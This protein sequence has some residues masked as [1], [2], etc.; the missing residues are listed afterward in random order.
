MARTH[1]RAREL[2][3]RSSLG[4]G[5]GR[6]VQQLLLEHAWLGLLG[7]AIGLAL[8]WAAIRGVLALWGAQIPRAGEIAMDWRVFAFA[9][10]LSIAAGVLAGVVPA[11][12]ATRLSPR[13]LLESGGRG[14]AKGGRNLAGASLVSLEIAL[15]L[16]LLTGAGLL[17]QSFRSL[18]A[19]DIGFDT[20]VATAEAT[21]TGPGYAQDSLRRYAYWNQ[22]LDEFRAIPGV[23]FAAVSQWIPLGLTG[24]GFVDV[25]GRDVGGL[26]AVYRTVSTDFFRT[27]GVPVIVG[28]TFGAEDGNMTQ[29]VVVI[30][31]MMAQRFFPGVNP[32]GRRVRARSQEPG[33]NGRPAPWLTIIGVVGDIRTYGLESDARPEMYVDFRQTPW[34]TATMTGLVRGSGAAASLVGEMRRRAQRVDPRI[35]VDVGT[36][37][38]RL[39]A[40]LATRSLTVSLLSA[41]AAVAVLLAALG[42]YGVLSFAV[43]QRRRELAVR[44]ALGARRGQLMTLVLR[45]GLKVVG[46]GMLFGAVGATWLARA[47]EA[48]LV[49]VTP[50]DPVTY[51]CAAAVLASAALAAITVPALRATT[52]DPAAALQAE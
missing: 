29:R 7:G 32:I 10:L 4:A 6:L 39:R 8:A 9:L 42:I 18:L 13:L 45:A 1:A 30:N 25:E 21:L 20:N 47:I 35:A 11:W 15:A 44:A 52:L 38:S 49:G 26:G 46:V 40:T 28:R 16:L 19:R 48:L 51:A 50:L 43:A 37:D 33:A 36:L 24:Q 22:L 23:R 17:I 34:R 2:A 41:F 12:D 14:A 5:R 27:L 3:V 31:R